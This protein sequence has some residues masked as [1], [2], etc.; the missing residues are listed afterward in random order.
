[1]PCPE[2]C[3]KLFVECNLIQQKFG[4]G[5]PVFS[6][7]GGFMGVTYQNVYPAVAPETLGLE[8][9][10]LVVRRSPGAMSGCRKKR[11]PKPS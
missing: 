10:A 2:R 8:D 5:I 7:H 1:M 6:N 3:W 11:P 4:F 9:E